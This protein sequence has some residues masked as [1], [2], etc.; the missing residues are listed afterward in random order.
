M[1]GDVGNWRLEIE[2]LLADE[3][4]RQVLGTQARKDVDAKRVDLGEE[5]GEGDGETR[6]VTFGTCITIVGIV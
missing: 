1:P 6:R 5:G 4:R 2:A 3:P